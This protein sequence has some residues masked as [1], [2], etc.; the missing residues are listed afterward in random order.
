MTA[1]S[2]T[3]AAKHD[4]SRR[5]RFAS[6]QALEREENRQRRRRLLDLRAWSAWH[7]NE[8]LPPSLRRDEATPR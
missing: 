8:E 2:H 5:R 4:R 3:R 7:T 6:L 1:R